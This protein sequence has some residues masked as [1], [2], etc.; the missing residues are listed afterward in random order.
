MK[1]K[2]DGVSL[3]V[4]TPDGSITDFVVRLK[5]PTTKEQI[6]WLFSQVAQFHMKGILQYTEDEI[7]SR[8]IIGN[9]NSSIFD[10]KSTMVIDGTFVKVLAWY[11]N[12]WGYSH[13]MID[14][15]KLMAR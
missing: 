14:L 7:V 5:K 1:G 13:R 4:P 3:R 8:D 9:P 10:A 12:E 11:D 15:V 2:L 6:N